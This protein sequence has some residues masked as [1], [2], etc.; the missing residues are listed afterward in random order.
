MSPE[1]LREIFCDYNYDE[2]MDLDERTRN[3]IISDPKRDHKTEEPSIVEKIDQ[4]IDDC[5][6]EIEQSTRM[7]AEIKAAVINKEETLNQAVELLERTNKQADGILTQA[8]EHHQ[9]IVEFQENTHQ[10]HQVHT[11]LMTMLEAQLPPKE[12][13]EKE[14]PLPN[15]V[16]RPLDVPGQIEAKKL[17]YDDLV[18][19]L[20]KNNATKEKG[21]ITRV[22]ECITGGFFK[23][24]DAQKKEKRTQKEIKAKDPGKEN[25]LIWTKIT[26][27]SLLLIRIIE[28]VGEMQHRLR[29]EAVSQRE[30]KKLNADL[31]LLNQAY[32]KYMK[33]YEAVSKEEVSITDRIKAKIF[34]SHVTPTRL[35]HQKRYAD[36]GY[37][38]N[39]TLKK[40]LSQP[41]ITANGS[42]VEYVKDQVSGFIRWADEHP[43]AAADM[44]GDISS[45][46]SILTEQS[47]TDTLVSCI[48]S[49]A[50]AIAFLDALGL[51][52][53]EESIEDDE[54]LKYRAL[55]DLTTYAPWAAATAK[56][57]Q[58]TI[59]GKW[60]SAMQWLF[61]VGEIF[62]KAAVTKKV[63]EVLP[64]DQ[65]QFAVLVIDIARGGDMQRILAFQRNLALIQLAGVVRQAMLNPM[66]V[67]TRLLTEL[68][69]WWKTIWEARGNERNLRIA[70]QLVLPLSGVALGVAAL[71]AAIAG[72]MFTFK[73]A[74]LF[75]LAI[76]GATITLSRVVTTWVNEQE[77][78]KATAQNVRKRLTNSITQKDVEE[79]VSKQTRK[80]IEDLKRRCVLPAVSMHRRNDDPKVSRAAEKLKG[81]NERRLEEGKRKKEEELRRVN[82]EMEVEDFVTLFNEMVDVKKIVEGKFSKKLMDKKM[83]ALSVKK[84]VLAATDDLIKNWLTKELNDAFYRRYHKLSH[85]TEAA[86]VK[87][88]EQDDPVVLKDADT[89]IDEQVKEKNA[90]VERPSVKEIGDIFNR[91]GRMAKV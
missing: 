71:V 87:K 58:H 27:Y 85:T 23:K 8:R 59:A 50:Y 62:M 45:A 77:E 17:S 80:Y 89:F 73:S 53:E 43:R 18:K 2:L 38:M 35:A 4:A 84:V 10:M 3:I 69:I 67:L 30:Q 65:S 26:F 7:V 12:E 33:K 82:K 68:D 60:G 29:F 74:V 44:V 21:F 5:F 78:Y 1:E 36:I 70:I 83:D 51:C 63:M 52:Q 55:A 72:A 81:K 11:E 28:D 66:G 64:A 54:S 90:A 39:A 47:L 42:I 57:A 15:E 9:A 20:K 25:T 49:R 40:F 86:Y 76:S 61:G 34:K 75:A 79:E 24:L 37:S 16:V 32:D 14:M 31:L 56:A 13:K 88:L 41:Q 6:K 46:C 19:L 91:F 48:K 22:S